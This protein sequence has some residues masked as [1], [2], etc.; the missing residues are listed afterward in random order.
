MSVC[1]IRAISGPLLNAIDV[2]IS[3]IRID[4]KLLS[5]DGC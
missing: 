2:S 1:S 3:L 4:T 5:L